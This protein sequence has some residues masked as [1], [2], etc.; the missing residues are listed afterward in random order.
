MNMN[1]LQTRIEDLLDSLEAVEARRLRENHDAEVDP[2]DID[3]ELRRDYEDYLDGQPV[4]QTMVRQSEIDRVDL[5]PPADA[6]HVGSVHIEHSTRGDF[7]GSYTV[8]DGEERR[9]V[10]LDSETA[11]RVWLDQFIVGINFAIRNSERSIENG[12]FQPDCTGCGADWEE[13]VKIMQS[14]A[15]DRLVYLC[16]ECRVKDR[17]RGEELLEKRC[18]RAASRD[19]MF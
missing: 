18:K 8:F 10:E 9:D 12:P 1:E 7:G 14:A 19:S 15:D 16:P 11:E 17:E 4:I 13:G 5:D 6:Q 2:A 3:H